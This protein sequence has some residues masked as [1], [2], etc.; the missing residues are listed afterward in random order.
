[1]A[2]GLRVEGALVLSGPGARRLPVPIHG[3]PGRLYVELTGGGMP[4]PGASL[5]LAHRLG[6]VLERSG[7]TVEL[8]AGPFRVAELGRPGYPVRTYVP[9]AAYLLLRWALRG[10]LTPLHRSSRSIA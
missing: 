10:L 6:A 4:S 2:G 5:E 3:E 7:T 1:M 8:V 9:G